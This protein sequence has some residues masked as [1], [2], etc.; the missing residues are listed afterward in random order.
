MDVRLELRV[1]A[2]CTYQ[3]DAGGRG[4][5]KARSKQFNLEKLS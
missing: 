1:V 4:Q 2:L 5:V 3:G